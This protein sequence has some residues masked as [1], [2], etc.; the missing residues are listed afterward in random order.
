MAGVY[1][2]TDVGGALSGTITGSTG[3]AF[4]YASR[5]SASVEFNSM[6]I[7]NNAVGIETDGDGMFTLT[8]V[9]MSNTK[10]VLITALL[11]GFI[12]GSIDTKRW[13][14]PEPVS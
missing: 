12:E 10:G 11:H 5:T 1:Y 14:S 13:K 8:D 7:E 3:A 9:V 2:Q 4:K 6:T